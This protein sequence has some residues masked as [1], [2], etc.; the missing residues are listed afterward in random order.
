MNLPL[1]TN[2]NV[3]SGTEKNQSAFHLFHIVLFYH[4]ILKCTL[5]ADLF[6]ALSDTENKFFVFYCPLPHPL[7]VAQYFI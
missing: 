3:V 1:A 7:G 5:K 6:A 2:K 4:L